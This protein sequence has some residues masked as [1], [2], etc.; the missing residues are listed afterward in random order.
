MDAVFGNNKNKSTLWSTW[1]W[2]REKS[3]RFTTGYTITG[4]SE[5]KGLRKIDAIEKVDELASEDASFDE[6]ID[7]IAFWDIENEK[8]WLLPPVK[9]ALLLHKYDEANK[10]LEKGY[11]FEEG[12]G[13]GYVYISKDFDVAEYII[14]GFE[15]PPEYDS[16]NPSSKKGIKTWKYIPIS[17]LEMIYADENLPTDLI[18]RLL[19]EI[20][21]AQGSLDIDNSINLNAIKERINPKWVIKVCDYSLAKKDIFNAV[22]AYAFARFPSFIFDNSETYDALGKVDWGQHIYN[23][24]V[25]LQ[26]QLD[27]AKLM[28][29]NKEIEKLKRAI[30]RDSIFSMNSFEIGEFNNTYYNCNKKYTLEQLNNLIKQRKKLIELCQNKKS[31]YK[32]ICLKALSEVVSLRVELIDYNADNNEENES[33]YID[34]SN[35]IDKYEQMILTFF[36]KEW[37]DSE[38]QP[39][40]QSIM[41]DMNSIQG[42]RF[43]DAVCEYRDRNITFTTNK[44]M[45]SVIK[46]WLAYMNYLVIKQDTPVLSQNG[47]ANVFADADYDAH[48]EILKLS[49]ILSKITWNVKEPWIVNTEN[50][51]NL[52]FYSNIC[53]IDDETVYRTLYK[54]GLLVGKGI[55]KVIELLIDKEKVENVPYLIALKSIK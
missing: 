40:I 37:T 6:K 15:L 3:D 20:L 51:T 27:I 35:T 25:R 28:I 4:N 5:I 38:L 13:D 41:K 14:L 55:E 2:L 45:M 16:H 29:E 46:K 33:K 9:M 10:L 7:Y 12:Y 22:A 1:E 21:M 8:I 47:L 26:I 11:V 39:S 54:T 31:L 42:M 53:G 34:I 19:D 24:K 18:T 44:D 48:K 36:S 17:G 23:Y 49:K 52:G 43:I 30:I 50:N 32:T